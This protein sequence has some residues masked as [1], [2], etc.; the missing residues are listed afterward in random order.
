V[1]KVFLSGHRS[2]LDEAGNVDGV[3]TQETN[4]GSLMLDANLAYAPK[5]DTVVV[6]IKNGGGISQTDTQATLAFNNDLSL[7]T[8]TRADLVE[9]L[10]HAGTLCPPL[11][12]RLLRS[13]ASSTASIPA[14]LQARASSARDHRC[15]W[16]GHRR[17]G[18]RQKDCRQ[19]EGH[20]RVVTLGFM[21]DSGDGCL[22]KPVTFGQVNL[23]DLD[24][25]GIADG[26]R[27]GAAEF[28]T[29]GAMVGM[30]ASRT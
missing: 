11:R 7:I 27:D 18:A 25:N 8:A 24:G 23:G 30:T 22:F 26:I 19:C 21:A 4:R 10:D 3:R 16:Q 15:R 13:R 2:G 20:V 6:S 29:N 1:S 12:A 5:Y 28:G 9:V 17:A 14:S